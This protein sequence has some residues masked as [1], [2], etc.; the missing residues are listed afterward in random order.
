V[1]EL[2]RRAGLQRTLS[3]EAIGKLLDYDFPGNVRE[4]QNLVESA[5]FTSRTDLIDAE[6]IV[7]PAE[8][9]VDR[10]IQH[11]VVDDFWKSVARPYTKRL[12]TRR[13]V[14]AVVRRAL[15]QTGGNYKKVVQLFNMPS[16]DYKRFMDF[17]R[18]HHCNVDFRPYRQS[19]G[20]HR[21]NQ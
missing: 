15:E 19:S 20:Q 3:S 18:R 16:G 6:A 12:I 2:N 4:L 10:P 11:V 21:P 7:L 17:L 14:E 8:S 9:W 1:D 5:Y 13:Q